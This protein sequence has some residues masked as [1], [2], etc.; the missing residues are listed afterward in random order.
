MKNLAFN[1]FAKH[2]H[3]MFQTR[4]INLMGAFLCSLAQL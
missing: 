2:A 4:A 3:Y 1:M